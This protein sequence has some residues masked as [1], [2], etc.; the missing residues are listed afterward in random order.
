MNNPQPPN[1]TRRQLLTLEAIDPDN[2]RTCGVMISYDRMRAVAARGMGAAKEAGEI[3]PF[4]LRQPAA[5]F[6]GL[7]D[8]RDEDPKGCGFRC[9][10]GIPTTAFS[11]DGSPR[12]PFPGQVFLVFVNDEG[13]AYNWRWDKSDPDNPRLPADHTTRFRSKRL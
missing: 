7:R 5:I 11:T 13:V 2:G 3:V 8:D 4:I 6:E 9:Y 12:R 10:C 1:K